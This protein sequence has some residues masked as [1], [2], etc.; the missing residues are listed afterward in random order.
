[1]PGLRRKG[2]ARLFI[3][4]NNTRHYITTLSWTTRVMSVA[5]CCVILLVACSGKKT[6]VADGYENVDSMPSMY[7]RDVN[8]LISDSGVTRYRIETPLWYMY[9][10]ET[11][12][13]PYW[14]FPEGI[15]VE[16]FDTLFATE[17]L[18]EGDTAIYYK[19]PQIWRLDGNVHIENAEGKEFYT[20]QLFW[21]QGAREIYS[22]S[23]IR[24]VDGEEVIEGIGFKSN[25]QI[26][27]YVILKTTGIFT[28]E[29]QSVQPDTL[30]SDTLQ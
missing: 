1:M 23:A 11:T 20:Q 28:V 22:D 24:I 16:Q 17:T 7:T 27:K 9:E 12:D 10:G 30:A 8:T 13:E 18:I 14:Y 5:L 4:M 6:E 3:K 15:Y 2:V 21:D 25:E 26:T 29:R 19:K